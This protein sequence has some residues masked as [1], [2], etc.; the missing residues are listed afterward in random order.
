VSNVKSPDSWIEAD[1]WIE[2]YAE[3]QTQRTAL[4]AEL[5]AELDEVRSQYTREIAEL[6]AQQKGLEKGLSKFAKKHRK[7][8]GDRRSMDRA[9]GRLGWRLAPPSCRLADK[10]KWPNWDA[11]LKAAA[12][13]INKIMRGF[14]RQKPILDKDAILEAHRAGHV[15]DA[16]LATVGVKIGQTESFFVEPRPE[17]RDQPQEAA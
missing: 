4:E 16:D 5:K 17:K 6:E 8:F 10:R 14:V 3:M 11:V 1:K 12:T 15:S 9:H 13:S 2:S 7:E